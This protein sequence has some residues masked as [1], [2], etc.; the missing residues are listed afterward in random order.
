MV[1]DASADSRKVDKRTA[2]A[3]WDSAVLPPGARKRR[4]GDG[5]GEEDLDRNATEAQP[6]MNF[7]LLTKRGNKQQVSR[8]FEYD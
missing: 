7:T 2:M 5:E 4:V 6:V 1:T 3:L 8:I